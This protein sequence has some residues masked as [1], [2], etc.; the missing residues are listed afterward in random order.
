MSEFFDS[1]IV[2]DTMRE[3]K[4]MQEELLNNVFSISNASIAEKK[5][6]IQLM[7][8]FLEK[9]KVLLFRMSLSD[10]IEAI[11]TKKMIYEAF[12]EENIDELFKIMEES[13]NK[14]EKKFK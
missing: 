6:Y 4:E 9:Q 12:Q 14:I 3:L 11:K 1:K 8:D 7:K 2:K 5:K 13:I 10:D